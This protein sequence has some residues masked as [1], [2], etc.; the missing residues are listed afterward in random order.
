MTMRP[1]SGVALQGL[2]VGSALI[3]IFLA[4]LALRCA[5]DLAIYAMM[6]PSGF[7]KGDSFGYLW[8]AQDLIAKAVN[9]NAHGWD[10]LG[11]DPS[12]MPL[13][14]WLMAVNIVA[15]GELAPL[16]TVLGQA[17]IDA[18]TCLLVY[19]IAHCL[20]PRCA[21]LA[22]MTASLNPTQI[23]LAGLVY[24]DTLFVFFAA[25]A[26]FGAVCWMRSPT[27]ANAAMITAGLAGAALTRVFIAFWIPV[28]V[29]FLLVAAAAGRRLLLS[30]LLHFAMIGSV[31]L[32]SLAPIVA[33][34]V[35]K[36]GAWA[37][38]PQ[39]GSHLAL[40]VVPL[41]QEGNDGTPWAVGSKAIATQ[42]RERFP[43]TG[44]NPFVE[45]ERYAQFG[46]ERLL[47][48][49]IPAIIKA[50]LVGAAINL[51][52]PAI[53]STP[54][55]SDL[56]RTG[57]YDT[58]GASTFGKMANF[59]FRSDNALYAWILLAGI[60]G[61]GFVRL[62]QIVGLFA[63]LRER[64][65]LAPLLLLGLWSGFVLAINGPIASPKYRL[66][67]EPPLMVLTGA[68]L[69]NLRDWR[70]KRLYAAS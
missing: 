64:S 1:H 68:G 43:E 51:G 19:G 70:R 12:S 10:W 45:S 11:R 33:R 5:Y 22:G 20:W 47:E 8:D 58:P 69:C 27:W 3:T 34:N 31:I 14:V 23:I 40:W 17:V 60:G 57:F 49:G 63:L 65:A 62:I 15:A 35:S 48:L 2:S 32:L 37:L 7:M 29:L 24:T 67:L 66:P 26:L 54:P 28:L 55:V 61:L 39:G 44:N 50:W 56:P 30:H 4:A 9:G 42:F 59:M 18:G 52:T 38:T 46:R 16:S 6:G 53:I 36:Y 41:V 21:F 13:F 25:M